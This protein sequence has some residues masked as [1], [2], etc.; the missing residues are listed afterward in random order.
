MSLAQSKNTNNVVATGGTSIYGASNY[1]HNNFNKIKKKT[2]QT[3]VR[4]VKNVPPHPLLSFIIKNSSKMFT[5]VFQKELDF[6]TKG[7]F[8]KDF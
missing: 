5:Q 6:V 7:Y 1:V 3:V 8:L 4:N 2:I